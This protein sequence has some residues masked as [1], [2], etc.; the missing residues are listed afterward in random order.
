MAAISNTNAFFD[1]VAAYER[2]MGRYARPLAKE[3]VQTIPLTSGQ[4]VLDIGCGPGALTAELVAAVGAGAVTAIDP[5]PPFLEYCAG[6]YPGVTAKVA[7]AEDIPFADNRFD[8]VFSQLVIH[9]IGDLPQAGREIVRVTKPG[10]SVAVC[11]W[12][13]ERM[14][15][16]NLLPR[17][18]HAA[19]VEVPPL[20][21]LE[22]NEAGSVAGYLESIGLVDVEESTITVRSTYTDFEDLWN[23]YLAPVGP[24]GPW[25]V[26]QSDETKS[27]IKQ[28]MSR[29]LGDPTGEITLSGEA[30]VARGRVSA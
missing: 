4:P 28:A 16:I 6:Q 13:V 15:K 26:A 19:G 8:A 22:F 2:F 7:K 29:I 5:S 18:S 3:F 14:Q 17:A 12:N 21:V 9:F 11:T 23:A 30:R 25:I 27:I 24:M 10:G 1:S 20:R